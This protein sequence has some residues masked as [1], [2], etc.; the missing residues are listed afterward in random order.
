MSPT[1]YPIQEKWRR[2]RPL[3]ERPDVLELYHRELEAYNRSMR[4]VFDGPYSGFK[5]KQFTLELRPADYDKGDWRFGY[6]RGPNPGFWAFACSDA[7]HWL[8]AGHMSVIATLEPDRPWQVAQSE[9]HSTIV[10]LEREL[11]FDTNFLAFGT[12]PEKCWELAVEHPTTEF[13]E[14]G[15]F[16]THNAHTTDWLTE[17]AKED[18]ESLWKDSTKE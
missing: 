11:L 1:Y 3:F 16:W 5:P 17:K 9:K 2:L 12:P 15:Q 6:R 13:L 7:C 14:P 8:T 18:A 4:K 10:D